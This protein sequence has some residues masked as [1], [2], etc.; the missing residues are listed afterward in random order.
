MFIDEVKVI[1][2]NPTELCNL[3]CNFCPRSTFY[4]NQ[5]L[6]MTIETAEE[7]ARQLRDIEY[8]GE[9]SI[10]GRGEPTL[11][12]QFKDIAEVFLK[13]RTWKLKINTNIARFDRYYD[14]IMQ[15]E[16]I[17]Y[18]IYNKSETFYA[19]QLE[20]FKDHPN[21]HIKFKPLDMQWND[22][23]GFTNR[24]GSFPTNSLPDDL[25]CEVIF[26]KMFIDWDG[27]Y[28]VCC[29]DWKEKISMGS[30]YD[31]SIREYIETNEQ[32]Q[33]YRKNLINGDRSM[34]PCTNCT[35][36]INDN[37]YGCSSNIWKSLEWLVK[38]E[39]LG[40]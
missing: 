33:K 11:H 2:I 35:H 18:N 37:K 29:E 6:N 4:K 20:R 36:K 25:R 7:I 39:N 8:K 27:T 19:Q 38:T 13:D 5:N 34:S 16:K 10:T 22:R 28:R 30:I 24:A 23:P 21:V 15:F 14:T 3:K 17:V 12:P 31:Q 40:V 32:L 1:E 26:L 9:V